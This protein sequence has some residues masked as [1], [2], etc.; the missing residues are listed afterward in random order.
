MIV[1]GLLLIVQGL[2]NLFLLPLSV[3]NI[4]IDF[5]AS[6]PVV[7]QFLEIVAYI[8]PWSNILPIIILTCGILFFKINFSLI[9]TIW[10]FIPFIH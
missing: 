3:L 1:D 5:L 10:D 8:I 7:F 4:A 9:R 6:I 2:I